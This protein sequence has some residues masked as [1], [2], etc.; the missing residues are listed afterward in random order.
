MILNNFCHN[1]NWLAL[2]V[3][4]VAYF[5]IGALWYSVLF[6]KPWMAGH[7]INPPTPEERKAMGSKMG[8]MFLGTFLIG[9]VTA[10]VIGLLVFALQSTTVMSGLKLGLACGVFAT[11]PIWMSYIYLQKPFKVWVI[12]AGYHVVSFLLMAVIISIWH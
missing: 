3:A 5:V 10:F 2:L 9:V 8:M 7:K 1:A 6:G 11:G 12:D 4:A